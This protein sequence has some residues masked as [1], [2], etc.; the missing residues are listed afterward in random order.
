MNLNNKIFN[1][2]QKHGNINDLLVRLET[3][4]DENINNLNKL[5]EILKNIPGGSLVQILKKDSLFVPIS[6]YDL[7]ISKY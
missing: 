6:E 5:S 7:F 4:I 2:Y 1:A 3:N